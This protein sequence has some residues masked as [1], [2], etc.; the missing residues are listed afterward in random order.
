MIPFEGYRTF[1]I[2]Y[3]NHVQQLCT[4]GLIDQETQVPIFIFCNEIC[5]DTMYL[6]VNLLFSFVSEV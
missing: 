1:S 4:S 3:V 2:N 6:N 5:T